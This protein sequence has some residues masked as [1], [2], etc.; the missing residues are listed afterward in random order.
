MAYP[1]LDIAISCDDFWF[2]LSYL[3]ISVD[4]SKVMKKSCKEIAEMSKKTPD[5]ASLCTAPQ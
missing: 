5:P 3:H 4:Y 1:D 2:L